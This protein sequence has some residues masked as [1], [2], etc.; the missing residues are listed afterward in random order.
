MDAKICTATHRL[1]VRSWG[2]ATEF[3]HPACG[4]PATK[5]RMTTRD[6]GYG[7]TYEWPV[8]RCD[9]HARATDA[10]IV[11]NEEPAKAAEV[12]V[13]PTGVERRET[14]VTV[15]DV[16][17]VIRT[18]VGGKIRTVK[19]L[20]AAHTKS[21]KATV[22]EMR[23][24]N[25][26]AYRLGLATL[27]AA[28]WTPARDRDIEATKRVIRRAERGTLTSHGT[29]GVSTAP[30]PK[31]RYTTEIPE[32]LTEVAPNHYA[33]AE[34]AEGLFDLPEVMEPAPTQLVRLDGESL[35]DALLK[36]AA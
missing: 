14:T 9:E 6:A 16:E 22:I 5:V 34:A 24:G 18:E 28:A 15:A 8:Y 11:V 10:P 7:S 2:T 4:A 1:I 13:E 19:Q 32:Y 35:L 29:P 17:R 3:G 33:T 30:F 31:V 21:V 20:E 23:R 26:D 25:L 27:E 12:V 36:N